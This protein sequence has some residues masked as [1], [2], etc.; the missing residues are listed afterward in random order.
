MP[1]PQ[2]DRTD[3]IVSTL[4]TAFEPLME[5][6]PHGFRT[7]FRKMAR[8]PFAFYRGSACLFYADVGRGGALA[9]FDRLWM[10]D[11]GRRVWI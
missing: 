5:A 3:L 2:D 7:K 6:D 4:L 9:D 8:D 10:D 1:S 11:E